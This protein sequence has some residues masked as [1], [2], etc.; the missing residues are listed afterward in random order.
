MAELT[1]SLAASP[2]AHVMDLVLAK[3]K[4]HVLRV[5]AELD[6]ADLLVYGPKSAGKPA[7]TSVG[8]PQ[9]ER[10]C[11]PEALRYATLTQRLTPATLGQISVGR[12]FR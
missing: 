1:S 9:G 2:N 3:V 7:E 5:F 4:K 10:V 8:L 6:I 12:S 11:L